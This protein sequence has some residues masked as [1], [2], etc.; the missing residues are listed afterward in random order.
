[1]NPVSPVKPAL[2]AQAPVRA[3]PALKAP[4]PAAAPVSTDPA[5]RRSNRAPKPKWTEISWEGKEAT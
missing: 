2:K 4:V 1:M 5:A 3:T